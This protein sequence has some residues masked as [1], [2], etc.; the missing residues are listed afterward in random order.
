MW[1]RGLKPIWNFIEENGMRGDVAPRVGAWIETY[2]I[3]YISYYFYRVA[4]RVGAWIETA[5]IG[6]G[7]LITSCRTPCGCVD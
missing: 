5:L 4:P 6:I 3:S 7:V 2:S 1:V